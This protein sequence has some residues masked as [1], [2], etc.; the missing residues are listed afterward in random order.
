MTIDD[1]WLCRPLGN[2]C[3]DTSRIPHKDIHVG[4][5]LHKSFDDIEYDEESIINKYIVELQAF[6]AS[7]H[8][9]C[10]APA[11]VTFAS[12]DNHPSV[13]P[14]HPDVSDRSHPARPS[15]SYHPRDDEVEFPTAT[16]IAHGGRVAKVATGDDCALDPVDQA[17]NPVDE[18]ATPYV[19]GSDPRPYRPYA[20]RG[21]RFCRVV[22]NDD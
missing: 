8:A 5:R 4:R 16:A 1:E 18:E 2:L 13:Y 9:R 11:M 15:R 7:C 3:Q 12:R 21:H 22:A 19:I 14:C 6:N 10:T 17:C 20:S